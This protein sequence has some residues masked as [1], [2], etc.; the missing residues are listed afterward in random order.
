ML[1]RPGRRTGRPRSGVTASAPSISMRNVP[2]PA[3]EQ[4]VLVVVVPRKL[5]VERARR[6][7]ASLAL[8]R[9]SGCHGLDE[10]PP[11]PQ[12]STRRGSPARLEKLDRIAIR[13]VDED[14][15]AARAADDVVAQRRPR[16][17]AAQRPT[18]ARSPTSITKRFQPP[19]CGCR[20]SGMG[21]AAELGRSGEPQLQVAA[22]GPTRTRAASSCC[23]SKP[24]WSV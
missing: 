23:V 9:S 11:L 13:V 24:R 17:C 21:R 6:T 2:R 8:A 4:L 20:P 16:P 19:G 14:L 18:G 1:V 15:L 5:A 12:R 22:A 3:Q 10:R 7:T